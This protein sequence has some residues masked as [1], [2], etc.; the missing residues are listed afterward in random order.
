MGVYILCTYICRM[1]IQHH[2]EAAKFVCILGGQGAETKCLIPD[3]FV[4]LIQVN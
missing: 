1:S 4:D 2:D 3:D